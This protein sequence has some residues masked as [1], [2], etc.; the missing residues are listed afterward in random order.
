MCRIINFSFMTEQKNESEPLNSIKL[1]VQASD[2]NK[3]KCLF[4]LFTLMR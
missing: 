3:C 4:H 2:A 1:E